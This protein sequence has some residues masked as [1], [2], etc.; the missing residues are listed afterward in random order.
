MLGDVSDLFDRGYLDLVVSQVDASEG[1]EGSFCVYVDSLFRKV[2]KADL[3]VVFLEDNLSRDFRKLFPGPI[4]VDLTCGINYWGSR[5]VTAQSK[6]V[7]WYRNSPVSSSGAIDSGAD[8]S[9]F[10]CVEY[11]PMILT[12]VHGIF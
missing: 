9:S 5:G 2:M 4:A 8:C 7:D 11:C 1:I 3:V 12:A 10:D 6:T